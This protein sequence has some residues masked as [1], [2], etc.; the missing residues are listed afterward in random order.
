MKVVINRCF[1]GFGISI[2]CRDLATKLGCPH[3]DNDKK[4]P[5][6]A[7]GW[8]GPRTCEGLVKAVEQLGSKNAS[9]QSARLQ[10][11]EIPDD[12]DWE[13]SDYDG[14]ESVHEKHRSW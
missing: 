2:E 12:V 10:I 6:Y 3:M 7:H 13:I 14:Q 5:Q 8:D 4:F 1:G 11:V 9:S